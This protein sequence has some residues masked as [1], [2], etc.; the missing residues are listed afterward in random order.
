MPNLVTDETKLIRITMLILLLLLLLQVI[1]LSSFIVVGSASNGEDDDDMTYKTMYFHDQTLDHLTPFA[2]S[3]QRTT[4]SQRYLVNDNN[5]GQQ[6]LSEIC[7]GPIFLYVGNEGDITEFWKANGFMKYLA[8]KYGGLLLFFEERYYGKSIPDGVE[9][10]KEGRTT[11]YKYLTTQQ[12]L[13]DTVTLLHRVKRE[14]NAVACPTIAFGGSYGATLA[15]YLRLAYPFLIQGA[16]ASSSEVGYYDQSG[17][18]A[19]NVSMYTFTEI[20]ARQY[21]K[22]DGC[23]ARIWDAIDLI[24][25]IEDDESLVREFNF[26][27]K[28]A[29]TPMQSSVFSYALEGLPQSNYPYQIDA[30]PAWPVDYS[31]T[32][33]TDESIPLLKRAAMVTSM[34]E[35][36]SLEGDC[37]ETPKE[38]PGNIPGDGPGLGSWGYQSCTETLH[39][40]SS[41]GRGGRGLRH[42]SYEEEIETLQQ[43][44]IDLYNVIPDT[45]VLATRYGGYDIGR[46]TTNT[47][48][49]TGLIDP[50]GGAS[51]TS[52][53]DGGHDASERGVYFFAMNDAAHHLDL[54]GWNEFDPPD[55][56]ATRHQ[57]ERIIMGWVYEYINTTTT[58]Q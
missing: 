43:T 25:S 38:G 56:I 22:T 40:F 1:A 7:P 4:Y 21:D 28:T 42:F 57:E 37:F 53:L 45:T 48:F 13:E 46:T 26:C 24:E 29:L 55:V 9:E 23:L 18:A 2:P 34:V 52:V 30:M 41:V 50:W 39:T 17:W 6:Q 33:L 8:K 16:L 10:E 27:N 11:P 12:V 54:R 44:C 36:Y 31:C 49:S 14:Y 51:M 35:G 15:S 19:H 3:K 58:A 47:I 20:V 5:F 32:I